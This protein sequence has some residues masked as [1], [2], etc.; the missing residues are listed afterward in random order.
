[1]VCA[2]RKTCRRRNIGQVE[3]LFNFLILMPVILELSPTQKAKRISGVVLKLVFLLAIIFTF[4]CTLN[5]LTDA[6]KLIGV[7]GIGKTIKTSSLIQNPVSASILVLFF[8]PTI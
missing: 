3:K 7:R 1:M 6:F 2:G 4:I 5:L 8:Y